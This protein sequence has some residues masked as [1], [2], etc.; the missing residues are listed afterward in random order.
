MHEFLNSRHSTTFS[1]QVLSISEIISWIFLVELVGVRGKFDKRDREIN[2]K[3]E[4]LIFKPH[5]WSYN[6][7]FCIWSKNCC[8]ILFSFEVTFF[9]GVKE[10]EMH[11]RKIE[12]DKNL[13]KEKL[14]V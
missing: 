14:Q 12:L 1:D 5:G 2:R 8:F 7:E 9:E 6:S 4:V 3:C 13:I 10:R 11:W